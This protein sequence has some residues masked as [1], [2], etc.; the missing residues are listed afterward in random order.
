MSNVID[1]KALALL[2]ENKSL[3]ELLKNQT[4]LILKQKALEDL[5]KDTVAH[6][7]ETVRLQKALINKQDELIKLHMSK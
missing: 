7:K 2:C 3:R 4:E 1:N 5:R 6:L